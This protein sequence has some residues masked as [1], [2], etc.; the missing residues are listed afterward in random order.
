MIIVTVSAVLTA[1]SF[2]A[3]ADT[4][5]VIG[6]EG[7]EIKN[8]QER[9][10]ELGFY[11]GP[12]TGLFGEQTMR[13][14]ENFQD[15]AALTPDGAAGPTTISALEKA[16]GDI[17]DLPA[18]E[19]Y[20]RGP[21]V[22]LAQYILHQEDYLRVSPSGLFRS[23]TAEAVREFQREHDIDADGVIGERT[24]SAL[25]EYDTP[26]EKLDI[27]EAEVEAVRDEA[28]EV[29]EGSAEKE[30]EELKEEVEE[31]RVEDE[32]AADES[33]VVSEIE[34]EETPAAEDVSGPEQERPILREGD[35][36]D[37]VEEAQQLLRRNGFYKGA[38]DGIYGHQMKLAVLKF[39][40]AAGLNVDG[41]LG[42]S[43][44]NNLTAEEG[45]IS[46]YTVQPG[47]SL[48]ALANR[49]DTSV[50][51]IQALNN[52]N[53]TNI[54]SGQRLEIPGGQA[55]SAS[56]SEMD[57]SRADSI[58][59]R[60]SRAI[61]T[62]VETGLSFE[63][64]RYGGTNH[65]DV[66][67]ISSRDTQILRRIYGGSWSWDRRA[68]VVHVGRHMIAGSI[69]GV[70]HGGQQIHNNDFPGHICL[71]FNN[72]R[73]HNNGTQDREHQQNVDRVGGEE[74]PVF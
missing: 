2:T 63:V 13:A 46:H 28:E 61:L 1:S 18:L 9:L 62:D 50:S 34:A 51:Q 30:P 35:R 60:N 73:L 22:I 7:E 20:S 65:A 16:E 4:L 47:D 40:K 53:S 31:D 19:I 24:W 58:L 41:V 71:H 17:D 14:V 56:V 33:G 38:I 49:F 64:K 48:W 69:N 29:E 39:Q 21:E 74:W 70:P 10:Q 36:G 26:A 52:L 27:S 15:A 44:W 66:E 68:V 12:N 55:V 43:T 45:E 11:E 25:L 54:R 5:F 72:S 23:L 67:P 42:P 57:W 59:P 6:E 32:D 8:L 3:R 37:A